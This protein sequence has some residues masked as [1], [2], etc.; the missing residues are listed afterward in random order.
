MF[1]PP[2]DDSAGARYIHEVEISPLFSSRQTDM[3][4]LKKILNW[5][6]L[7]L[8]CIGAIMFFLRIPKPCDEPLTYRLGRIDERFGITRAEFSR[9]VKKAAAVWGK[10][11]SRD[12]FRE[13]PRGKIEI[14]LIYD[15]RQE[16]SDK[17][18]DINQKM[19][20][21]NTS[22]ESMKMRYESLK[23]EREHKLATLETEAHA[24]NNRLN[25]YNAN[26]EFWNRQGGAPQQEH[27]RLMSEKSELDSLRESLKIRQDDM[28]R[29]GDEMNTVMKVVNATVT[30]HNQNVDNYRD[31]GSRLAGEFVEG[32]FKSKEGRQSITIYHF[33]NE[34]KLVRVLVH[35]FGHALGLDHSRNP[36]SVMYRLNQSD[37]P[38]LTADDIAALKAGCEEY[39]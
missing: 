30:G 28:N 31:V 33:D 4:E 22:I 27:I 32:F 1:L 10:P 7:F 18:K 16:I 37:S 8:I 3:V 11:L 38:E 26:V 9:A 15:Y 17:L 21:T 36:D 23:S 2:E 25:A 19:D 24:Y 34:A 29:L 13:D 12:L 39:K 35:E 20:G 5:G 14:N 6:F